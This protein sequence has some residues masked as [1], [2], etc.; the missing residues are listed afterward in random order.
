MF[1]TSAPPVY[2]NFI[3]RGLYRLESKQSNNIKTVTSIL[4]QGIITRSAIYQRFNNS[5]NTV[6]DP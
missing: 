2:F 3:A 1:Q 5:T 6:H 4:Q